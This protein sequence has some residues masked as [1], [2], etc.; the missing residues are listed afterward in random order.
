MFPVPFATS[1]YYEE[2]G[3]GAAPDKA[4]QLLARASRIVRAE[5][6][7]LGVDI[8]GWV[9]SGRVD[10]D[11]VAD[12][13]CDMVRY[14]TVNAG[15]VGVDSFS[16]GAGPYTETV[17]FSNPVGNMSFTKVHMSRLGVKTGK[18]WSIDLLAGRGEK[19]RP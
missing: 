15:G 9:D 1:I 8:D 14:A 4:N 5:C 13:V 16:Q 17:K 6:D 12:V 7:N 18:A 2:N 11:I 3:F 10:P 19:E